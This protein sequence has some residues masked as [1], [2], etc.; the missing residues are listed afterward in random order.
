MTR[1]FVFV[2]AAAAVACAS[3]R[4][5]AQTPSPQP[6]RTVVIPRIDAPPDLLDF[7]GMR[8][9]SE[10][11]AA[12]ARVDNFVQRWPADGQ[13]ERMKTVAYLGYTE[14]ALHVVY[15]AFDPDPAA[16]RAHMIRRE[17]VFNVND[18]AVELRLD[19]FGDARQSYYFVANPLGVQLDAAW[20]EVGGQYDESFD[21]VWHSRG[22]R[23][24]AG[25]V[26]WM[27]IPFKSLRF[28][29]GDEQ[30]WRIYLGRWMPRTGEWTFWPHISNRQQSFLQQMARVEGVRGLSR[31]RGAQ[32]IPY[33]AARAFKAI[34]GRDPSDVRF[35]RDEADP[36]I[37]LDAKVVVRDAFVL[38]ATANPDFSQVESDAPQITTNARF[39]VFFPE[40]RP[41]FLENAGFFQTPI[42]LLF[43]RRL[44]DPRAGLRLTGRAAG[45]SVA[46]LLADDK[47]P[48]LRVPDTDPAAGARAWASVAR[49]GRNV[50]GQSVLGATFARREFRDRENTIAAV[51]TRLRFGRVWTVDGQLAGSR[52]QLSAAAA[53]RGGSA[54]YASATRTGRTLF[55][56][57]TIEGRSATF[58][59]DLGFVPRTDV[60]ELT[61]TVTVTARPAKALND[62]GPTLQLHRAWAHDGTPLDW[63]VRPSIAFNFR[64]ATTADAFVEQTR[65][66]LRPGDAP[67]V[68]ALT[69][70]RP[71]TWGFNAS[72]SP[73]PS[74][75]VS[76]GLV[77]G[78][79]INFA[80]AGTRAPDVSGFLSSRL[81]VALR[82]L[83]P[84]RI[85]H[86]WLRTTLGPSGRRAFMT[87]ILR[88]QWAWQFT[89]EWSLRFIGQYDATQAEP[90][91]VTTSPQR[92]FNT[93]VLLTRLVNPW[94]AV[95]VGVNSNRQDL[96]LVETDAGTRVVRRTSSLQVDAWQVF[97]KWSHLLRW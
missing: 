72:T 26:V 25:F 8:P 52:H 68:A 3:D 59:T 27:A 70:Y 16:L 48:G 1:R 65:V 51:D 62:W 69:S 82:P 47:A 18:D 87:T 50:F 61:Q 96:D 73:R 14:D 13:P 90:S 63:R 54:Y 66:S 36:R 17:D 4:A 6:A 83:T 95:Y 39:E 7:I 30:P 93:D 79:A 56:K 75:S 41:F 71:N 45:W 35:V 9:A 74:W 2:I 88:S 11:A 60:H 43:T 15:V 33:V 32:L 21:A 53:A 94:T 23:T 44:A 19:T 5:L 40:K 38:D 77:I 81:R 46:A 29:P 57:T 80:P 92:R 10:R 86:T 67:N 76:G 28:R 78:Q 31:G 58:F 89:R 84:L 24:A 97:V 49:V 91:I 34:D 42:N 85:E 22:Q 55:S 37:G 12:M 20:P 64:R